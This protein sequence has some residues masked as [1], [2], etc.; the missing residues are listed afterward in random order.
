MQTRVK[1]M[2]AV[3]L[4]LVMVLSV[5]P[6]IPAKAAAGDVF[7]G[8]ESNMEN[9][10]SKAYYWTG[11]HFKLTATVLTSGYTINWELPNGIEKVGSTVPKT[12]ANGTVLYE[13]EFVISDT[14]AAGEFPLYVVATKGS[15]TEKYP[16]M[17]QVLDGKSYCLDRAATAVYTGQA[18]FP[19][20]LLVDASVKS[21]TVT[22]SDTS[23]LT[24]LPYADTESKTDFPGCIKVQPKLSIAK[25]LAGGAMEKNV[26]ISVKVTKQDNTV[27]EKT[28]TYVVKKSFDGF[29]NFK[30]TFA[31]N[32]QKHMDTYKTEEEYLAAFPH[33]VK[34]GNA[35]VIYLD[36]DEQV[37]FEFYCNGSSVDDM[38]VTFS[39][40]KIDDYFDTF[41]GYYDDEDPAV[42]AGKKKF[43]AI[44][45]A[46]KATPVNG[47][48]EIM[49]TSY[50]G[51][52]SEVYR[53]VIFD[54]SKLTGVKCRVEDNYGTSG[55]SVMEPGQSVQL[56]YKEVDAKEE[57]LWTI[58]NTI[59]ATVTD[60]GKVSAKADGTS[61]ITGTI[62]DQPSGP[63]NKS[64]KYIATV[65]KINY[66]QKLVITK[67]NGDLDNETIAETL[68]I[69]S[70]FQFGYLASRTDGIPVNYDSY[71]WKTANASIA[72]VDKDGKLKAV[73]KGE[74]ELWIE[75][76]DANVGVRSN[77]V[78]IKVYSP[79]TSIKVYDEFGKQ[80]SSQ[81]ITAEGQSVIL[82]AVR[83]SEA[84]DSEEIV[85]KTS[86]K[87]A[88]VIGDPATSG[89][90][91][92]TYSG[93][94][95]LVTFKAPASN[96]TIT[97]M[98]KR[99]NT[100][101]LNVNF[102]V[103]AKVLAK[104]I[105]INDS[106]H[107]INSAAPV[108]IT[109][110]AEQYAE[111][112]G[113]IRANET[114]IWS[115]DKEDVFDI[116][117]S[118]NGSQAVITAKKPGKGNIYV[119]GKDSQVRSLA[120]PVECL[121]YAT[122]ISLSQGNTN[123]VIGE[124]LTIIPAKT[125]VTCTEDIEW[126]VDGEGITLTENSDGSVTLKA[127][128]NY[129]VPVKVTARAV[130]SGKSKTIQ[131]VI[132]ENIGDCTIEGI[133]ASVTYTG[134]QVKPEIII[135]K[136]GIVVANT[137][138]EV[139]YGRNID[140]GEGTV[141]I[142]GRGEFAGEKNFTFKILP[143]SIADA[144]IDP[145][146]QKMVYNGQEQKPNVTVK[147]NLV[148]NGNTVSRGLRRDTDYSVVYTNNTNAGEMTITITGMGNYTGSIVTKANIEPKT[149]MRPSMAN[150]VEYTGYAIKPNMTLKDGVNELKEGKDY[151]ASYKNNK[152]IGIAKM[153]LVGKG[154]YTGKQEIQFT[155]KKRNIA[156]L[157][158]VTVKLSA[159]D[160]V[161]NGKA[162]KPT[163]KVTFKTEDGRTVTMKNKS[164][165]KVTYENN[166]ALSS[167]TRPAYVVITAKGNFEGTVRV[168]FY[169]AKKVSVGKA[170]VA[171]AK[172]SK[173]K[174][175]VVSLKKVKGAKGYEYAYSTEKKF[176]E[177]T[178]K[179]KSTT[180]NT[181][182]IKS[183]KK[184]KTYY[185]RARAYK[186][187]SAGRKAY[188]KWSASKT[189]KIKK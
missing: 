162:K 168:P 161:Y 176:K 24:V 126:I 97:A 4:S 65:R 45:Q 155:I 172:N 12:G 30:L 60:Q 28:L 129:G 33:V 82:K 95:C 109:L 37:E 123:M 51:Q 135:K 53:V 159:E 122:G 133:P 90:M 44:F 15:V 131:I 152:K 59:Y 146:K 165:Y 156:P 114:L 136:A 71:E 2:L 43:G 64:D 20:T 163:A 9:A 169:I 18:D 115:T 134:S 93:D 183:L 102:E 142:K 38:L 177:A 185:V 153:T 151:T 83:N 40:G 147:M 1:Q 173:S 35:N 99:D 171:S 17:I 104:R 36:K 52:I 143:A 61:I 96:V 158:A 19:I 6:A 98:A 145:I 139:K 117:P 130:H 174:A 63:R 79:I 57:I 186:K 67:K 94:S 23:V 137:Q 29:E 144:T 179:I 68:E 111:L 125:P 72:T 175:I 187:N 180:K 100:K 39:G 8:L 140:A 116:A 188:G 27:E 66:P 182:T 77:P 48:Q 113:D 103:R 154:N 124:E 34:N 127:V 184:G 160:F 121:V 150:T 47:T 58:D 181:L 106:E 32:W 49:F 107:V 178:T 78:K 14:C 74:T 13:Q 120:Y 56:T 31:G 91:G 141:T 138:Y 10:D 110:T 86:D 132:K 119:T 189:I 5:V 62:K 7:K 118:R 70:E 101:N 21:Y 84:S 89:N 69:G 87:N 88:A 42:P 157:H 85:W 80:I 170:T 81:Q 76:K 3:F 149:L 148:Q 41:F 26:N 108:P 22:S 54:T 128:A 50:S 105:S 92:D 55:G 112:T 166:K 164:H 11:E 167:L 73:G 75:A 46:K 25:S 16:K